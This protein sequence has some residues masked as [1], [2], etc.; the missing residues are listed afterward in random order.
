MDK[1]FSPRKSA[2]FGKVEVHRLVGS[3]AVLHG[4]DHVIQSGALRVLLREV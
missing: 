4:G 1:Q 2:V 3:Y